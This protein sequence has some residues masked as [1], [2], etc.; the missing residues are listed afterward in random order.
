MYKQVLELRYGI[1]NCCPEEDEQ[2]II[3][4]ELIDLAALNDPTYPCST[5]SCGCNNNCN[6]STAEPVCPP[7]PLT[8]N[9]FC[10]HTGCE[11]I[12]RGDGSGEY[13]TL[14]LCQTS[15]VPIPVTY[16]CVN[17]NC[18]D[19]GDG[20]GEYLTIEACEEECQPVTTYNCTNG[21]CVPVSGPL[22]EFPTLQDCDDD[23]QPVTSYNCVN[24][25]CVLVS[26]SGGDF[27]TL[28]ACEID[29]SPPISYNCVPLA[30]GTYC[31]DP[32][33]GTGLYDTII[34]CENDCL[35]TYNCVDGE[36]I[37]ISGPNG[38][39]PTVIDCIEDCEP[40]P[41]ISYNC[42]NGN[43]VEVP[44]S[45]G[46]YPTYTNCYNNLIITNNTCEGKVYTGVLIVDYYDMY[47][48]VALN[49][50]NDNINNYIFTC[51][52]CGL[53]ALITSPC[54]S[55]DEGC[56]VY[57]SFVRVIRLSDGFI[58]FTSYTP[59][60][61]VNYLNTNY[62]SCGPFLINNTFEELLSIIDDCLG[63]TTIS[64]NMQITVC[65]CDVNCPP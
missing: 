45:G 37:P 42:T 44:N 61:L 31:V 53:C 49:H 14:A 32:G 35:T 55:P 27:P 54:P 22:G 33:D 21:S 1:S 52:V 4:K 62:P 26:G 47:N 56:L 2:Y 13:S 25:Y 23:C 30:S 24:G 51:I 57:A 8:Y 40:L 34:E 19:P 11:C 41:G 58:L 20:L 36:C 12:E 46:Q 39:Y 17:N 18:T 48:W 38:Q 9:C 43:C 65:S 7:I 15:C 28:Q 10:T 29:C 5:N 6:C 60:D 59:N 64:L 63:F 16:N 3:Q 50:P